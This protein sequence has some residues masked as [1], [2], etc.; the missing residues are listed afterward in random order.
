[1]AST[2]NEKEYVQRRG[3]VLRTHDG[4]YPDGTKKAKAIIYDLCVLPEIPNDTDEED[5]VIMES[6]LL[7]NELKRMEIM[8][9]SAINREDCEEFIN[10]LRM[11][12][13]SWS[14][15]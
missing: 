15:F 1:M 9:K 7:K 11:R 5:M 3:R 2:G 6:T 8:A 13:L 4:V 10:K 14:Y 12:L